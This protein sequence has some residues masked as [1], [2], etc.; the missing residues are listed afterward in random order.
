[1]CTAITYLTKDFYFGRNLDL[2]YSYQECV[3]IAPR[4]YGF[5]FRNGERLKN[6]LAMIGMATVSEN[7]PLYYDATNEA[8][9]SLAALN[10]PNNATYYPQSNTKANIAPFEL[11]P[12]VLGQCRNVEEALALIKEINLWN[13][14]F[15]PDFPL[16]PLH[17]MLSDRT[18][19]YTLEPMANGLNIHSNKIGILTNNPPFDFQMHNLTK[20]INLTNKVPENRFS[21]QIDLY[22][23]SLGMGAIGLPG[24]PSSP[25]RFVKAAFTKLNS[26]S[27]SSESESISQFFHI[28]SAV[29]QQRGITHANNEEFEYTLYSSCCNTN[30]GIYYYTTYENSQICA[31]DMNKEN[32]NGRAL[33]S[34]P[35]MKGQQVY[36]QNNHQE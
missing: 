27:G 35:L 9:L 2:Y 17:W 13:T 30:K 20:Y 31:V 26:V 1:M 3:T 36:F 25:S 5:S 12:W 23:F 24:D 18:A 33:V 32:L 22:P 8:G 21:N 28:L 4:N 10:F 7:Y 11:I 34:Y 16:S 19:S 29:A 15:N 14:P 6:H